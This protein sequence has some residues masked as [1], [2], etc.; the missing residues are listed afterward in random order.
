MVG[1]IREALERDPEI[2][3]KRA[4]V[5]ALSQLPGDEGVPLLIDLV[6]DHSI[7]ELRREAIF[8]LAESGDPRALDLIEEILEG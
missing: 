5:F 1:T 8:W 4:A 7:P 3:V 2:E 6:R